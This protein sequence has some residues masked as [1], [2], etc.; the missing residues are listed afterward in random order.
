MISTSKKFIFVRI[1]RT[2]SHSLRVALKEHW[3]DYN[4]ASHVALTSH[5]LAKFNGYYRFAC[6][7]NPFERI[8]SAVF[9]SKNQWDL[10]EAKDICR[11]VIPGPNSFS[12]VGHSKHGPQTWFLDGKMDYIMRFENLEEDFKVVCNGI[13][14]PKTPLPNLNFSPFSAW[15]RLSVKKEH[16]SY[17]YNNELRDLVQRAYGEDLKRFG[18]TYE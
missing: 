2:G 13:G 14:L 15:R 10:Q 5:D 4:D 9:H 3:D 12:R 8:I 16:Y 6:V 18:Y 11:I 1:P 17:Y 7:R